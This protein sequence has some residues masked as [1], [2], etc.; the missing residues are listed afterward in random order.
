MFA[1]RYESTVILTTRGFQRH[2][3]HWRPSC[4]RAGHLSSRYQGTELTG[5]SCSNLGWFS[6]RPLCGRSLRQ[7]P[8]PQGCCLPT[9]TTTTSTRPG[10]RRTRGFCPVGTPNSSQESVASALSW[11]VTPMSSLEASPTSNPRT[12][13]T[14]RFSWPVGP[15]LLRTP[16]PLP[17][18]GASTIRR[19]SVGSRSSS[20]L[21]TRDAYWESASPASGD[22][23]PI[24]TSSWS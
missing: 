16:L 6:M 5:Q 14:Y 7:S 13:S 11:P 1:S 3:P 23:P 4:T 22:S 21:G 17:V 24:R 10:Y 18:T 12:S 9:L 20:P 2:S 8:Q 15:G 19:S